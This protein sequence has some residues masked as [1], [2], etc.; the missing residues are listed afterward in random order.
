[1]GQALAAMIKSLFGKLEARVLMVGLD[2][3]GK[4]TILTS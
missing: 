1:M 4:T 2:G 3:A